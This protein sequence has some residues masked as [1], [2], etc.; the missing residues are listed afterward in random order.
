MAAALCVPFLCVMVYFMVSSKVVH[1]TRD[2]TIQASIRRVT[3]E[4]CPRRNLEC[5][6]TCQVSIKDIE[7]RHA[8]F[9]V[10]EELLRLGGKKGHV[11]LQKSG[12]HYNY[13]FGSLMRR[14]V[15]RSVPGAFVEL[16]VFNGRTSMMLRKFIAR[17][18]ENR[19]FHVYDS[20]QG[21]PNR[22]A[23]DGRTRRKSDVA[24]GMKVSRKQFESNFDEAKVQLPDGIHAGFFGDIADSEYPDPIAFAY[25]DGDLYSSILDSFKKVYHKVSPGGVIIVHDYST[26]AGNFAGAKHAVDEFLR[27]KPEKVEECYGIL[28]LVVK[29]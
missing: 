3:A 8:T 7:E 27:D 6:L 28:A 24:G 19:K 17:Y 11:L 4:H 5:I 15:N 9:F 26:A 10:E 2:H 12:G 23:T 20:F 14:V 1:R 22:T 25:F 16:G 13:I 29:A 21:L 18:A